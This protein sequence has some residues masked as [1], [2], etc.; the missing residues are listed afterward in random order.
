LEICV[1]PK[2]SRAF[3][4]CGLALVAIFATVPLEFARLA[5][6]VFQS[7]ANS[8]EEA[9]FGWHTCHDFAEP[10]DVN[11]GDETLLKIS[12]AH[13]SDLAFIPG[14]MF[15]ATLQGS[16]T[17]E[18]RRIIRLESYEVKGFRWVVRI[19]FRQVTTKALSRLCYPPVPAQ[20][21]GAAPMLR[22]NN[23]Q[24]DGC[25][26]DDLKYI[27]QP[28]CEVGTYSLSTNSANNRGGVD[29]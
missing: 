26:F 24:K 22:M 11:E 3:A 17:K 5:V 21:E 27:E 8:V 13:V 10:E 6:E 2:R 23:I 20:N 16:K 28:E 29:Q 25:E 9:A 4:Q 12:C 19:R 1:T 15:E 7:V 18:T 14:P